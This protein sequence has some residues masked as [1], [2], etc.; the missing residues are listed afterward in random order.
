MGIIIDVVCLGSRDEK[1][2]E[3]VIEEGDMMSDWRIE[4]K[5]AEAEPER[6]IDELLRLSSAL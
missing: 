3:A 4:E 2:R 6:F 1:L 5:I